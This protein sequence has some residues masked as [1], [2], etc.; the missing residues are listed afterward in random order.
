MKKQSTICAL[1][2][3]PGMGAIALVRMSGPESIALVQKVFSKDLSAVP[4]HTAVHGW[5]VKDKNRIDDV[6]L[7]IFRAPKSFTSEDTVEIACHGSVYIQQTILQALLSEGAEM[8]SPGEFTMRAYLNGKLDLSQA[9]AVADLIASENAAM[10]RQALHQ[11]RGGFS[12][13][14]NGLRDKLLQ[15]ASLV[16]LELDFAEEDVEFADRTQLQKLVTEIEQVVHKLRDSFSLGNALKNGVP[17]A[18]LGAPN[19]GKSTLLNALLNEE[20]AI[21]SDIAGTTRDTVEDHLTIQGVRF[22]F[23]DT[24]GIRSTEDTIEKLGIERSYA[25]AREAS[26]ILLLVDAVETTAEQLQ[27]MISGIGEEAGENI[28]LIVLA[29]KIDKPGYDAQLFAERIPSGTTWMPLSAKNKIHIDEL[30]NELAQRAQLGKVDT[31][32]TIVTNARHFDA[33]TRAALSIADIQLGLQTGITGDFLAVDIR[34]TL[35]H[36]GEITGVINA[37]DLLNNIFSRFCIGK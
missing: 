32:E 25:K 34:K 3:A 10:H 29:N 35:Y 5:I 31:G 28:N 15:F 17:V 2:T 14:I 6:L 37:D 33:L 1:S 19:M 13:D 27:N 20:R 4:S 22:K 30:K 21:V 24:A 36:L 7:T 9:E 26:I 11:M 8:A 18:I 16:E 23:I 12:K